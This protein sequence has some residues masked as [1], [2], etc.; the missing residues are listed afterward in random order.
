MANAAAPALE[1][2]KA[3]E[4]AKYYQTAVLMLLLPA[5]LSWYYYGATAL[6]TLVVCVLTALASEWGI[7]LIFR[8]TMLVPFDFGSVCTGAA[9]ALML[10]ANVPV[11]VGIGA[12]MFAVLVAAMPFGGVH[13]APFVPAAAGMAF[14]VVCFKEAVF[15]YPAIVSSQ[16]APLVQ[17]VSLASLLSQGIGLRLDSGSML[18]VVLGQIPGPMGAGGLLFLLG[19]LFFLLIMGKEVFASAVGYI[20]G[21]AGFAA[22]FPRVPTG[23]FNS[24]ILELASGAALLCG[25]ALIHHPGTRPKH[26]GWCVGF[27]FWAALAVMCF[28]RFGAYEEGAWF[29]LLFAGA[30]WPILQEGLTLGWSRLMHKELRHG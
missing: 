3:A 14:A 2:K 13:R 17:G 16:S 21:L 20:A 18:M 4:H 6:H 24:V 8:K 11:Y 1:P 15:T 23:A 9:I 25:I 10:P 12:S 22:L 5:A 27:G 7:R 29:A 28:R 30:T 19:T 26:W